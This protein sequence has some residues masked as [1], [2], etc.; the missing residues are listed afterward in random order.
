MFQPTR[1]RQYLKLPDGAPLNSL[2]GTYPPERCLCLIGSDYRSYRED[3]A[4]EATQALTGNRS[5]GLVKQDNAFLE[6]AY[7]ANVHRAHSGTR[8]IVNSAES[9]ANVQR[10]CLAT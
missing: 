6:G 10:F 5:D 2:N 7:T 4:G 8:G 3:I 1:M 9:Y